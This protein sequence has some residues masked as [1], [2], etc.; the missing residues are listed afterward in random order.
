MVKLVQKQHKKML[1]N[2][3]RAKRLKIQNRQWERFSKST[4]HTKRDE[5]KLN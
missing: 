2:Y 5:K 4:H 3:L 1:N